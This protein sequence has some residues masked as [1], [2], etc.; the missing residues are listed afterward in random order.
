MRKP[1]D[2]FDRSFEWSALTR[3]VTEEHPGATIGTVSGR[4]RQGKTYLL[5][6]VCQQ[7]GGFYFGATQA[8][9][10]ESLEL[11]SASLTDH[12][13]APVPF[14]FAHWAEVLDALL[15]LGRDRPV[16][17]VIDEFPYLVKASPA[18]P[19]IIQQ[20][21]GPRRAQRSE[22][23]TRLLLCGS[24][25]SFMGSL[26]S[27]NAPLRGRVGLELMVSPLDYQLAAEFWDI[28]DP[29]L[30]VLVNAVVGGTPAYRREFVRNDAPSDLADFD[31]WVV[32]TVL[33]PESPL[34][35]EARYLLAEEPDVRNEALYHSVLAAIANGNASRGGIA[36]YL[37]RKAPDI[38]HP[39]SVLEA[40]QLIAHIPDIFRDNRAIFRIAEPLVTFYHTVMRPV[41]SQLE[42]P[43]AAN[44]VWQVSRD[45]FFGGVV[46]PHFGQIC[47]TWALHFA[48]QQKW[49]GGL[50]AKVG[51]G[52][53]NDSAART[54]HE[55]D[56]AVIGVAN[57]TK[58]PLLSIGE[59]KWNVIMGI[60]HIDRLRRI[61][62]LLEGSER[63]NTANTKL[64]CYSAAGFTDELRDLASNSE[65]V[66]LVD[67]NDLYA[68]DSLAI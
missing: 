54:R 15:A 12:L 3:F 55:V 16:P 34:F 39:L 41:W 65:D 17:V 68:D 24:S 2:M 48:D 10:T 43:G 42:R 44:R 58:P 7:A 25:M 21:F 9:E 49:W 13:N 37:G 61:K 20:A 46:G 14:H 8:T 4:R 19:S 52:E 53:V 60:S 59:A 33:N 6:A 18:L 66:L 56:V 29:R 67:L 63:Y 36:G 22:S 31:S 45:R 30:A 64:A 38:A 11:I 1:A 26:L 40:A 5:D 23:R 32:R 47:R 51:S 35:R 57:G 27:G 50:A 62:V 28:I